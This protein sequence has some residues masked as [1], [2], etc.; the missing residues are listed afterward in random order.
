MLVNPFNF[1]QKELE[2][3]AYKIRVDLIKALDHAKSGHTGGPLGMADLV[4]AVYFYGAG[5]DPANP[6]NP[7][8]DRI[9][10]SAG[11][12]S[13][14]IYGALAQAGYFSVEHFLQDY[15]IYGGNL[16]GHP[17]F[18]T[19][20][21]ETASGPL[22]Q[23]TSQAAG[24]AAAAKLDKKDW[25]TWLFM[26]D[27]EQ[28]EGQT[29]EALMWIGARK[30]NNIVAILDFNN[31]QID[32]HVD[33]ILPEAWAKQNY[34]NYGW[35]IIDIRGNNMKQIMGAIDLAKNP[36]AESKGKPIMIFARTTPGKGVSFME[37]NYTWHG[38]PPQGEETVKALREL[39]TK[40]KSWG[41]NY[42]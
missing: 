20:G 19:P 42:V 28:Q 21:I 25:R 13:P 32:N 14:L 15:R 11:H 35:Y 27:G 34:Q 3:M 16:D 10:F 7:D 8:R 17:N 18:H 1:K 22:A 23:G 5:I 26:S 29:Q 31:M 39:T 24:L 36:P 41:V 6:K 12:Y 33:K 4:T 40:L 2:I 30:L 37:D 38:K 9:V